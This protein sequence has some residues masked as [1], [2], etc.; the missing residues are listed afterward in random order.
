M[1]TLRDKLKKVKV[2]GQLQDVSEEELSSLSGIAGRQAPPTTPVEAGVIGANPDQAKMAGT[3]AQKTNALRLGIQGATQLQ[4]ALRRE[5]TR[6]TATSEEAAGMAKGESL[7]KLGGLEGRVDAQARQIIANAATVASPEQAEIRQEIEGVS[8]ENQAAAQTAI[9]NFRANPADPAVALAL[10]VALGKTQ[11]VDQLKPEELANLF[12]TPEEQV[13]KGTGDAFQDNVTVQDLDITSLGYT[14]I[15]ELAELLGIPPEELQNLSVRQL[16]EETQ[17]QVEQEFN[18]TEN[19]RAASENPNLGPAERAEARKQLREMG[20]VGVKSAETEIDKLAQDIE[21]DVT[22]TFAGQEMAISDMLDND[23]LSSLAIAYLQS[24]PGDEARE[25]LKESEPELVAWLEKNRA[26]LDNVMEGMDAGLTEFADIQI[27]NR[28]LA[29]PVVGENLSDDIMSLIIPSWG[30]LES[31]EYDPESYPILQFITDKSYSNPAQQAQATEAIRQV[32]EIAPNLVTEIAGLSVRELMDAG[33]IGTGRGQSERWT[34]YINYRKQYNDV[35]NMDSS[36]PDSVAGA[37]SGRPWAET[38]ELIDDAE[39][40]RASGLFDSSRPASLSTV[41]RFKDKDHKGAAGTVRAI[42]K[43]PPVTIK[44]SITVDEPNVMGSFDGAAEWRK[45]IPSELKRA[46]AVISPYYKG[47]SKISAA[48]AKELST[49]LPVTDW[50]ALAENPTFWRRIPVEGRQH[51]QAAANSYYQ[52][53][54]D[55]ALAYLDAGS[56]DDM[57]GA[58]RPFVTY[59]PEDEELVDLTKYKRA[60]LAKSTELAKNLRAA[61]AKLTADMK[62][63]GGTLHRGAIQA[64]IDRIS[65]N[66]SKL[67]VYENLLNEPE[68]YSYR[69]P[70]QVSAP[71]EEFAPRSSKKKTP[72]AK[73]LPEEEKSYSDYGGDSVV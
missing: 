2:G 48:D 65:D 56:L 72:A 41:L 20:A 6:S 62:L 25:S 3:P 14:D 46:W 16:I 52:P 21:D 67:S 51:I 5:Q 64:Q 19:I 15:N 13:A 53:G 8:P 28:K 59:D 58:V 24:E 22:V 45:S 50:E 27:Q 34:N 57:N 61:R 37:I 35:R 63:A 39:A 43:G 44:S 66:I 71:R 23:Y 30:N 9:T 60:R 36:S 12:L 68:P 26:A 54:M 69:E 11:I 47:D 73:G 10:N 18:R 70:G 49:K 32:A 38:V 33:A 17:A 31:V 4:D 55:D 29:T 40:M 42:L 1:A 7:K